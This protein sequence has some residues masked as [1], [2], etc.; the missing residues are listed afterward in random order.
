[1]PAKT[2]LFAAAAEV[3]EETAVTFAEAANEHE[4]HRQTIAT[5]EE[6]VQ[7]TAL[8][9][10]DNKKY[11]QNPQATVVAEK[12]ETVHI[13]TSKVFRNLRLCSK[14]FL[15]GEVLLLS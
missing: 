12:V 1:M 13:S 4:R 6:T 7:A 15:F 8:A 3:A 11:Y 5:V 10:T 2:G 9:K 14:N